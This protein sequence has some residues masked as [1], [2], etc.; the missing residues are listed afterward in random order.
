MDWEAFYARFREPDFVPGYEIL[1]R[2]GGGAFGEVYKARKHSIGKSFAIKFLKVGDDAARAAIEREL[3]QVRHFAT[4]D[5]PNLVTVEDL[6]SVMGVPYLVMGYAGDRTL[7]Q[8][9]RAGRLTR[10]E[11][12]RLFAQAAN[13]VAALHELRL[14]H[15]DLKPANIFLKGDEVRVGDYGLSRLLGEGRMTL[16]FSRGTP[17]YM[18]PEMLSARG[19]ER[20][21]IYSLGV[22]LYE[23]LS[24]KLPFQSEIPGAI[25]LRETDAPPPFEPEFPDELR[26]IVERCLRLDPARR[27][28]SVRELLAE[29]EALGALEGLSQPLPPRQRV[30]PP[31]PLRVAA[32]EGSSTRPALIPSLLPGPQVP[33]PLESERTA[34]DSTAADST[35]PGSS[36]AAR[37]VFAGLL[38]TLVGLVQGLWSG[39]KSGWK[40][41]SKATPWTAE[42]VQDPAVRGGGVIPLP[43]SSRARGLEW[44][45]SIVLFTLEVLVGLVRGLY[46]TVRYDLEAPLDNSVAARGYHLAVRVLSVIFVLLLLGAVSL[47]VAL[48]LLRGGSGA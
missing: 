11:A 10:E 7:A 43:P 35:A 39:F 9:L 16:S 1:N 45:L 19:D 26:R 31:T 28:A 3:E 34:A 36:Q 27:Y 4:I 24:G 37:S 17:Q 32:L 12:L 29:L 33:P 6:G 21:D 38:E 23:C 2:L 25:P 20:A 13:G 18:A 22:I 8:V 46:L 44:P 30:Q 5:H 40:Q 48:M 15:F 14:A 47:F 41:S 42:S